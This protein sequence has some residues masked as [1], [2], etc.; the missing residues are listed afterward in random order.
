M[1]Q[2]RVFLDSGV[3]IAGAGSA[4]GGSRQILD[5][6][7][8]R[9][10]YPVTCPQVLIESRRNVSKKLPRATAVL[11]R[12]IHTIDAELVSNPTDEE[13]AAALQFIP[14]KDAPILAAACKTNIDYLITLDRRHFKQPKVQESMPFLILLPEEFAPL[15]RRQLTDESDT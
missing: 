14:A 7:T 10:L 13:I 15:I 11:E 6:G 1:Q 8:Q 9:L 12:I 4:V 2:Y 5:W 3:Y